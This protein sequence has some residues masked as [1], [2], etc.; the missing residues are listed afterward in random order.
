LAEPVGS[1]GEITLPR[2]RFSELGAEVPGLVTV[3]PV[4]PGWEY[5]IVDFEL[6]RRSVARRE[7][8][9]SEGR[10]NCSLGFMGGAGALMTQVNV[11]FIETQQRWPEYR[12]SARGAVVRAVSDFYWF[13]LPPWLKPTFSWPWLDGRRC[14][15]AYCSRHCRCDLSVD[16]V[17]QYQMLPES[18]LRQ[19]TIL[20][21]T[22]QA[23][24]RRARE[25]Q[26]VMAVDIPDFGATPREFAFLDGDGRAIGR[27]ESVYPQRSRGRGEPMEVVGFTGTE[28]ES[29]CWCG[30]RCWCA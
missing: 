14:Q 7:L 5:Q 22:M 21:L 6:Q 17:L 11:V 26:V 10:G 29:C 12:L 9:G 18:I 19:P 13:R 24:W 4:E 25:K 8:G 15:A 23:E 28:D 1:G 30:R 16:G 27:F 3:A 20:D 2:A